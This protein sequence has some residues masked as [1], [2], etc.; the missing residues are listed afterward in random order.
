GQPAFIL[1]VGRELRPLR[2]RHA[3]DVEERT[4]TAQHGALRSDAWMGTVLTTRSTSPHARWRVFGTSRSSWEKSLAPSGRRP[5]RTTSH[6]A[7]A[8]ARARKVPRTPW[9]PMTSTRP[10]AVVS[11]GPGP[12]RRPTAIGATIARLTHASRLGGTPAASVPWRRACRPFPRSSPHCVP[13]RDAD[14][15]RLTSWRR[16]NASP[17]RRGRCRNA[18]PDRAAH[19]AAS[20]HHRG[21]VPHA[22]EHQ[23][24]RESQRPPRALRPPCAPLARRAYARALDRGWPAGGPPRL[25]PAAWAPGSRCPHPHARSHGHGQ[26]EGGSVGAVN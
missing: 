19:T 5:P 3:G 18:T 2:R 1:L 16:P 11:G 23:R 14:A 22:A 17:A 21:A 25:P 26:Q 12:I 8:N 9:A 10:R 20:G 7:S 24:D 6:P 13:I 15:A 4:A